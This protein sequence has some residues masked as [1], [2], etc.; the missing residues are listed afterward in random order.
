MAIFGS[1]DWKVADRLTLTA[2]LRYTIDDKDLRYQQ[3][4]FPFIAPSLPVQADGVLAKDLSPTFNIRFEAN[5][6]LMFYATASRGF[7]SGGGMLTILL[8]QRSQNS[9]NFAFL[10]RVSGIMK[11]A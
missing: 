3:I 9:T 8:I 5:D 1:V 2:G 6:D 10:M 4:G 11:A 7:K